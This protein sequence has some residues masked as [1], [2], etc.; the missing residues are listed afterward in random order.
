VGALSDRDLLDIAIRGFEKSFNPEGG[1]QNQVE[2][3]MTPSRVSALTRRLGIALSLTS[4]ILF[5]L[6]LSSCKKTADP[7]GVWRGT[8]RN[9]SGEDVAFTLEV[10]RE[11]DR[12]VGAL[13]NGTER[14]VS[15]DGSFDGSKLKLR[16]D[17]Y[18]AQLMALINGDEL[19]GAFTRQWKKQTLVRKLS[20]K[21]ESG[22]SAVA[23]ASSNPSPGVSGEWVM[24]VGEEPKLSYWRAAFKQQG[25][26]AEGTIIPL[27]GDWG[28]MTGSFENNQLTLNRFDGINCRVF[29]ATLT[30]QGT[31]EGIV[32]F[33]LYDPKRKV[34]AE[35]L[36]AENKT[37]V[38][39][40]PD[41]NTYTR[42]SNPSEPFR[43]SFPDLEGRTVSSTDGRFKNKV[44]VVTA[45][46]SWCPNCYDEG[47]VLQEFYDRYKGQGLEVVAL[48]FEYT[49]DAPRDTEQVKIF[50]KR[51]GVSYPM[52]YAGSIDDAEKKLPQLVNFG[53]YPTTI[54]V[55][56][57]GLVKKIH[58]GFEGKATGERFVKLKAEMEE[59]IQGLLA[60]KDS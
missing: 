58:A 59:L 34:V 1:R 26:K 53:A 47:P 57:D 28:E 44:V 45:T 7:V 39:S 40:L 15:T 33:G 35:R 16:Y 30:P 12:I 27:S 8:I 17:F 6:V 4:L 50:A 38:A 51:L 54:Y 10:K 19:G 14:T 55:G 5:A 13:V 52:L 25:A 20:A 18:D 3:S 49:G 32:D 2:N 31:L 36:T 37:S 21:R 60:G 48:A 43:F 41:P 42:M 11:G 46:G 24:R 9:N 29:K 22:S 56:R 23:Q